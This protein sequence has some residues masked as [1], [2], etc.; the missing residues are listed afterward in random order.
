M[1]FCYETCP[2][3]RIDRS[4]SWRA[5]QRATTVPRKP[6][7]R[8]TWAA[9]RSIN[10]TF[11]YI[12]YCCI[13]SIYLKLY[14]GS[15]HL[16]YH[17]IHL[18]HVATPSSMFNRL[19]CCYRRFLSSHFSLVC[20]V[21]ARTHTKVRHPVSV[22]KSNEVVRNYGVF[23]THTKVR[24]PAS[25]IKS[26]KLLKNF[27]YFYHITCHYTRHLIGSKYSNTERNSA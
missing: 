1:R 18:I 2:W 15:P 19:Y 26:N 27:G 11:T 23:F 7:T 4:T 5:V 6:P 20:Y 10:E 16:F 22:I 17:V 3:C 9:R 25:V 13:F 21:I 14:H 12:P 8:R 24:H